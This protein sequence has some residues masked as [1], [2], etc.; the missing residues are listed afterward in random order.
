MF[1]MRCNLL[2]KTPLLM[3]AL[4][5]ALIAVPASAQAGAATPTPAPA[6]QPQPSQQT[7]VFRTNADLV[8]V[9]VVVREKK[10]GKPVEGLEKSEFQAFEDGQQQ[11]L[12][13]F[14]EHR[15]T[16]TIL[17]SKAPALPPHVY[18]DF[19]QYA[20]TSAANVLLLDAL[21]TP[22]NDQKYARAQMIR[23]L[24]TIPP[25][26]RI[27]VFTLGSK[28]QMIRGFTTDQ[29]AVAAA[30]NG[31]RGAA[32]TSRIVDQNDV[33][34]TSG[35]SEFGSAL[36]GPTSSALAAFSKETETFTIDV[37]K[38][39]TI[40]ALEQL[41]RFLSTVPGRKN[42]IWSTGSFPISLDLDPS[43]LDGESRDY[44]A[45]I[46]ALDELLAR[47]RVA[48]Y[49]VDARALMTLPNANLAND[50]AGGQRLSL[51]GAAA[52]G[53]A[54]DQGQPQKWW[55][56]HQTMEQVAQE[57]GGRAYY[58]TNAVGQAVASAIAD[59][60]N[61]Y[62]LG[63][64]PTNKNYNGGL[65][66][67]EVRLEEK[68]YDVSYR[69]GYDAVDPAK[70]DKL[71]AARLSPVTGGMLHGSLPLSQVIFEVRV[72]PAGDPALHGVQ[73]AAGPAVKPEK[74]LQEPV[75]RYMIDY[76]IDPHRLAFAELPDGKLRAE[77]EVAQAVYDVDGKRVNYSD[78]GLEV[79]LTAQELARAM[80]LGIPVHEEIDLPAGDVYVRMGV[81]DATSG[82]LGTVEIGVGS[83]Q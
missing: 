49:P 11:A 53:L 68:E 38:R 13:V 10:G 22:L 14:E 4:P 69:R 66:K 64:V 46:A 78:T 20:I 57:T 35:L 41:G 15:A 44:A 63:Y 9:D 16:D 42:L 8:L 12:T 62:T 67:I 48:V 37:R 82:R 18:S 65:R 17:A 75:R 45:D 61:Y 21:N 55:E 27:A 30:I 25:G 51:Q 71:H 23:Y 6:A 76:S 26:A 31:K 79:D 43:Q 34:S 59:G 29:G 2:L 24:H 52:Q 5:L 56:S 58:N 73:P 40:A 3:V 7:P 80:R 39:M 54:N 81:R 47:A 70:V 77:L 83:R 33:E 36:P 1:G 28:L 50:A 60:S 32:E 72:L 19:P 74:P